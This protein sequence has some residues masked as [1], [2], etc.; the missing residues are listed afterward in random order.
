MLL[1]EPTWIFEISSIVK[2]MD[3]YLILT[4]ELNVRTGPTIVGKEGSFKD[5]MEK[6]GG[7][8]KD[9]KSTLGQFFWES[10]HDIGEVMQKAKQLGYKLTSTTGL[11]QTFIA[12]ME[13]Q[14]V[15]T[16]K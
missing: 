8:L 13:L 16:E 7:E 3:E 15:K 9:S 5:V 10:P 1:S 2:S 4:T 11:G 12:V 14:P 6:L